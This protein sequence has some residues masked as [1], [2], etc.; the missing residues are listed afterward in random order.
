MPVIITYNT[1]GPTLSRDGTKLQAD[2]GNDVDRAMRTRRIRCWPISCWGF[3]TLAKGYSGILTRSLS[4]AP[5]FGLLI[6]ADAPSA[7]AA[8]L[9]FYL[10]PT[11][12]FLWPPHVRCACADHALNPQS[13]LF[14]ILILLLPLL[15]LPPLR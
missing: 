5:A 9:V 15:M 7:A 13:P 2:K 14:E 12:R 11:I 4:N 6:A 1:V 10:G 3:F 8:A